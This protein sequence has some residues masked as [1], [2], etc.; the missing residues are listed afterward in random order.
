VMLYMSYLLF[1]A[2]RLNILLA[3]AEHASTLQIPAL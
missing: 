2:D 1:S 3:R